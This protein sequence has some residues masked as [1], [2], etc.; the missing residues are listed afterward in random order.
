G[1][2][3]D[4]FKALV[5]P[6]PIGWISTVDEAGRPN[7]APY[8]F[9]NGF[10]SRPPIVGFSSEGVKHSMANA[11]ATG[12]FVCNLATAALGEAMNRTS[13]PLPAGVSEFAEAGL[14]PAPCHI[15]AAPRVAESPAALECRYLQT[16][17][18]RDLNGVPTGAF[19]VLGQV[20]GVHI[21]DAFIIDGRV[22]TAAMKPLGRLGY[23]DYTIVDD[24]F[25][26]IRPPGA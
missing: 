26:M 16:V 8:S 22:D 15:V 18:L 6:R 14:T 9:F 23:L 12:A 4:P 7:L 11:A 17:E 5:A 13:A 1:L 25:E 20:V 3:H 19:L 21:E 24:R 2:P 10:G